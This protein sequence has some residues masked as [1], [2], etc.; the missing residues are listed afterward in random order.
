MADIT[1]FSK[2]PSNRIAGPIP[3]R[4]CTLLNRR[5]WSKDDVEPQAIRKQPN[6]LT[7][8]VHFLI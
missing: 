6:S 4:H 1:F 5:G 7:I 2:L 3:E 8:L